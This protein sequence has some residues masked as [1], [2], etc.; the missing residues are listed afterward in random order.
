MA[1]AYDVEGTELIEKASA[2]LKKQKLFSPPE[3]AKFVKTGMH[4]ERPPV[5]DDWW[6]VRSASILR[7]IYM[8][9]PVGVSKLRNWYGGRK[10]RGH[11]TEHFYKGSGSIIRKILQQLEKAGMIKFV[12]KGIHKGRAITPSGMKLIDIAATEISTRAS[13]QP[14]KSEA[15]IA[16]PQAKEQKKPAQKKAPKNG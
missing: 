8:H 16:E 13:P 6:Y 12:Q 10:R 5:N 14:Q 4:K 15:K 7:K 2:E 1:T 11:K 9:G 3:W